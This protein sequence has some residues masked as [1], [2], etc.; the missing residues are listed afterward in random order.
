MRRTK[1]S[2]NIEDLTKQSINDNT[3]KFNVYSSGTKMPRQSK[4]ETNNVKPSSGQSTKKPV[5]QSIKQP[6]RQPAKSPVRQSTKQSVRQPAKSPVRQTMK[7]IVKTVSKRQSNQLENINQNNKSEYVKLMKKYFP[8]TN[9]MENL[10]LTSEGEYSITKPEQGMQISNIVK[11]YVPSNLTLIDGTVGMGGDL[12]YLSGHFKSCLAVDNNN[13]HLSM[14]QNNLS[15]YGINNVHYVHDSIMNVVEHRNADV[16]WLD[17]PWGGKEYKKSD[18]MDLYIDNENIADCIEKWLNK[19]SYVII[20]VPI[21]YNFDKI[22]HINHRLF[23]IKNKSRI[24]FVVLMFYSS[25]TVKQN[26]SEMKQKPIET[27]PEEGY[28]S[29]N[30]ETDSTKNISQIMKSTHIDNSSKNKTNNILNLDPDEEN[31]I[32]NFKRDLF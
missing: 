24:M 2:S 18:K 6:V 10:M 25:E 17:P 26:I 7:K 21:N 12:L 11:K 8:K 1:K 15:I 16:L 23:S 4:N 31:S 29:N 13:N 19:F 3:N 27:Q 32:F 5:R 28:E 9:N 20:K 30:E 14:A 22:D